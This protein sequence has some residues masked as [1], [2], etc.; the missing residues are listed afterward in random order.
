MVIT[1]TGF[2]MDVNRAVNDFLSQGKDLFHLIRSDGIQLSDAELVMLRVQLHLLDSEAIIT[3]SRK[4]FS[5]ETP[6]S[7]ATTRPMKRPAT[8]L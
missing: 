5:I 8:D 1:E 7:S 2:G 3:Q 6:V 4:Q